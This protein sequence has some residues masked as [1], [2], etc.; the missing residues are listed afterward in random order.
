MDFIVSKVAM[1]IAAL[2]TV[3]IMGGV[4]DRYLTPDETQE[5]SHILY[6]LSERMM[7]M[8]ATGPGS[9]C[10]WTVP[11]LSSG[12]GVIVGV[13]FRVLYASSG[14]DSTFSAPPVEIHTWRWNGGA[15]NLSVLHALDLEAPVLNVPSGSSMTMEIVVPSVGDCKDPLLF[16]HTQG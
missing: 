6:D 2:M 5:L 3:S 8:A 11:N 1:S 13:G 4:F 9:S 15:L 7:L 12:G 14:G 16:V 10:T